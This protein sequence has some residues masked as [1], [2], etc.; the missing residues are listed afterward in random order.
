M[1]ATDKGNYVCT[2][3]GGTDILFDAYARYNKR[4]M[5]F[6]MVELSAYSQEVWCNTCKA[7]TQD[8]WVEPHE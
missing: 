4:T 8:E 7:R 2:N 6:E 1:E 3:C 5:Q